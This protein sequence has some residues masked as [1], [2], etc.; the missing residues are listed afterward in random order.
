[1]V[2][3]PFIKTAT[4]QTL[5]HLPSSCEEDTTEY[6]LQGTRGSATTQVCGLRVVVPGFL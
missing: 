4:F 6:L 5:G 1:V 2:R 3:V